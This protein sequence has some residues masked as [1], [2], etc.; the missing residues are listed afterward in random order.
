M[1]GPFPLSARITQRLVSVGEWPHINA[2]TP[3]IAAA[4]SRE[5][6]I[7]RRRLQYETGRAWA[8]NLLAELG[9]SDSTV[10][11]S[12]D[13]SPI[14]PVGFVGSITHSDKLVGVAIARRADAR[15][16]GIDLETIIS[17]ET[18]DE[19]ETICLSANE[20]RLRAFAEMDRGLFS[21]VC[22]SAKEALFKCLY[23]LANCFFDFKDTEIQRLDVVAKKLYIRL[24]RDLS[25]E[26]CAGTLFEGA[27]RWDDHHVFTSF[28][29]DTN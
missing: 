21:T 6:R 3:K 26:F 17:A 19:I 1:P 10:P 27:Y 14:W 23:P 7:D 24:L 8:A 22:F 4:G 25:P 20:A 18:A 28:E 15:S 9:S 11:T 2:G 13:R 5:E 29:L 16:L 12:A